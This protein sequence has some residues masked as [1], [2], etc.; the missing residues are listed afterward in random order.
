MLPVLNYNDDLSRI[1]NR[2]QLDLQAVNS[3]VKNIIDAVK[4]NGDKALFKFSKEFDNFDLDA[5]NIF[6]SEKEITEAV[7]KVDNKTLTAL[8]KAKKNIEDYHARQKPK[9]DFN[10]SDKTGFIF[11][12]VDRVGIY[13]PGGKAAYPSSVLMCAIPAIVAGVKEIFVVTPPGQYLNQLT[14]A[15]AK[16]CG[17][18]KIFRVGGAQAI[19]ALAYGTAS[20]PK[21]DVIVGP[22]NIYVTVAKKQVFGDVGI[23]MIAGP[24]EI[25]II[26]DNSANASF[27]AADLL[28]QAEHDELAQSVLV[29]TCRELADKVS[30]ELATKI[31]LLQ[32]KEIAKKSLEKYGAIVVCDTLEK[33][34]ILSNRI[35]PEHLELMVAD[36]Q[37]LL[38]GIKHAGAV[39][40]GSYSP[41]PLGDY[42]AGTN[43]VLPTSSTARFSSGLGVD[44]FLKRIS[45]VNYSKNDLLKVADDI[46]LLA[47]VEELQAHANSVIIRKNS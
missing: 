26:A 16:L 43:H 33:A 1:F 15:A 29:T 25:L 34:V 28:S 41:E 10:S 35:A 42:Y 23:D 39:F 36:P 27:I 20:V 11:K 9:D 22:G 18:N 32:K 38:K 40:L 37:S 2:S 12:P 44:T 7:S 30:K 47:S 21:V 14:I 46:A 17:V 6:L 45:V 13:V 4:T 3:A 31:K 5:S 24:S 19:A 8:K